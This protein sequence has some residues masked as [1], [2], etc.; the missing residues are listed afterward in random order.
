MVAETS[1][2][3]YHV[4]AHNIIEDGVGNRRQ[5]ATQGQQKERK[6]NHTLPKYF[7]QSVVE[8]IYDSTSNEL[9]MQQRRSAG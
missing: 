7:D 9:R 2:V 5:F 4:C 6:K 3:E 8:Y 1:G